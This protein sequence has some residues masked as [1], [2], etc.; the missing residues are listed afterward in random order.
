MSGRAS[1]AG[2]ASKRKDAVTQFRDAEGSSAGPSFDET[3]EAGGAAPAGASSGTRRDDP[4]R[5]DDRP[6]DGGPVGADPGNGVGA[7]PGNGVGATV[8]A[9]SGADGGSGDS[10]DSGGSG[11]SD[12]T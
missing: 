3:P 1:N 4:I 5:D 8:G 6:R 7:D 2:D 10:G 11:G 9:G 12:G